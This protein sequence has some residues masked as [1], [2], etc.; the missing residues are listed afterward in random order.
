MGS[1]FLGVGNG[2][3][4]N[5]WVF[6]PIWKSGDSSNRWIGDP[7]QRWPEV[8]ASGRECDDGHDGDAERHELRGVRRE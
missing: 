5:T 8:Y 4:T 6:V 2:Y 7:N 3:D 1:R